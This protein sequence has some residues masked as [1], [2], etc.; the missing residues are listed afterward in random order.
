M[1][2][3]HAQQAVTHGAC[4]KFQVLSVGNSVFVKNFTPRATVEWLPRVISDVT[5]TL[6]DDRQVRS[7][8]DHI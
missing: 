2:Q 6:S 1:E 4:A 8:N 7:Q 5:G 3:E